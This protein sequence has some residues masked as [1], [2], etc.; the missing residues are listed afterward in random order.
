MRA[1]TAP[2]KSITLEITADLLAALDSDERLAERA[3]KALVLDLL[4]DAE[5]TQ[6]QAAKLLGVTRYDILDLMASH[7]IPSGPFTSEEVD[8]DIENA[9]RFARPLA[10]LDGG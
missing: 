8:R 4:R 5:I 9:R 6:G 1:Q 7:Y 10:S 3:W 2:T